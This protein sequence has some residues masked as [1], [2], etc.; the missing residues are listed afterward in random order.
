MIPVRLELRN[1]LAYRAP[2]PIVFEGISLACLTGG[3]GVGK[4]SI[5]DAITWGLW[6]RARAK[7]D[8]DLIHLGQNEMHVGIDF[9]QDGRR[10]RVLRRR[11][12]AGRGSRGALDLIVLDA[13]GRPRIISEDG[14][15]RTQEKINEILRLDYE[16]FVHSAFLQQGRADAFTLKTAAERKRMLS[17]I[18][19]L[20]QWSGYEATVKE[21]LSGLD[22]QIDILQHDIRAID[23]EI[24]RETQLRAELEAA[25]AGLAAAQAELQAAD[26]QYRAVA[27]AADSL[28]RERERLAELEGLI[29]G[30]RADIKATEA[31]LTRAAAKIDEYESRIADSESIEAG[32]QQLLKA[33]AE[34]STI[35]EQVERARATESRIH[36]LESALARERARLQ[37]EAD[38]I[39]ERI[40]NLQALGRAAAER[41]AGALQ[42][43]VAELQALDAR[44]NRATGAL[45][46]LQ[47]ERGR[48]AARLESLAAEGKD[49][50][51]RL[52]R[53]RLADGATCP[54]CGQALT[55]DHRDAVMRQLES[56]RA[57]MRG[58]Y[59][60]ATKEVREIAARQKSQE[61]ELAEWAGQLKALP[62][63]QQRL[64][65]AQ[66]EALKA[67]DAEADLERERERLRQIETR[68]KNKDYGGDL[69]RRIA[70]LREQR[71]QIGIDPES[72]A[73]IKAQVETLA[74][75][76]RR[77]SQL[78]DARRNL[79]DARQAQT[80]LAARS[81]RLHKALADAGNKL[82][83]SQREI[84]ALE[85][86]VEREQEARAEVERLRGAAQR[87]NERR[88]IHE[89][90][91]SAIAAGRENKLRLE[92]RLDA[93]QE[94]KSLFNELRAAFGRNGL[95]ALII[96]TALPELEADANAL[97][98]RMTGGRLSLRFSA[99]REKAGGGLLETLD[100]D[101]ADDRGR[102]AY[103]LYSGGEAFRINFAIRIALSKLLARRAGA[104]LRTLFIDEGFGSQDEEGR[105][106][107]VEAINSI[108]RDFDLILVIT[109]IDEL[110]DAFPVHLLVEKTPDGSIL[111]L[112]Q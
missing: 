30:R 103:E 71:D 59:R 10:Y 17:E 14:V 56:D 73:D 1:F 42:R 38:V 27:N 83:L 13:A 99:Q 18:L 66:H 68:L 32:Y 91:L 87:W 88:T 69:R 53:L 3:N 110:R 77:H 5:L 70:D 24:A 21:R 101:I 90:E 109:H 41:D 78:A 16:T 100:I 25:L 80:E 19:G 72:Q 63:L 43:D 76:D 50:N 65:A 86:N 8:E 12:R 33:R 79:P 96:E 44:R 60:R 98:A 102:R 37:S 89:Q 35:A 74:A 45:Q 106:R 7:R 46:T 20:D 82:E 26:E 31:E 67:E 58:D 93:A 11:A 92:K 49:I 105:D 97:L 55:A 29:A 81:A 52:E 39:R 2:E 22:S 108:R 104:Q 9:E 48:L 34:Q 84:A 47:A 94:E 15:R 51:E 6:G 64:G 112:A 40:R 36:E 85:T 75:Y 95:P 54:L 23:A 61:G 111:T 4:S 107:L 62:A 28:R 57:A